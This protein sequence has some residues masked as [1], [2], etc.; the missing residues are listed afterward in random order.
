MTPE[1]RAEILA[2]P[3]MANLALRHRTANPQV[4]AEE[5]G[6]RD[7]KHYSPRARSNPIV[8]PVLAEVADTPVTY[9]E[10]SNLAELLAYLYSNLARRR[11]LNFR[12]GGYTTE[13]LRDATDPAL[14]RPERVQTYEGLLGRAVVGASGQIDVILHD[15]AAPRVGGAPVA[16]PTVANPFA[17][18]LP[19]D[20]VRYLPLPDD[21]SSDE[22][23]VACSVLHLRQKGAEDGD[24]GSDDFHFDDFDD[25]V[26]QD[27]EPWTR[28]SPI[29]DAEPQEAW[30]VERLVS[31]LMHR[32]ASA[33]IFCERA[34]RDR[35]P[36]WG[37][38]VVRRGQRVHVLPICS[39][40]LCDATGVYELG[41]LDNSLD[42]FRNDGFHDDH[43]WFEDRW[44]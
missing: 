7:V 44:L 33:C 6:T 10:P 25:D 20:N 43:G 13:E 40:C 4:D 41:L 16:F 26:P 23:G 42:I 3:Y 24:E 1:R 32:F 37:G 35:A 5:A 39:T 2:K 30:S 38:V 12:A 9:P 31:W 19:Y 27:T 18:V 15:P 21:A 34:G 36:D 22:H 8:G 14:L 28:P 29:K 11:L 17:S